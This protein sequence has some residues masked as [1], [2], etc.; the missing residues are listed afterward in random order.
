MSAM[1]ARSGLR[2]PTAVVLLVL[3]ALAGCGSQV[4]TSSSV[5][6]SVP[7]GV[8]DVRGTVLSLDV[9]RR[10][11]EIDQ[12]AMPGVMPAM[13]MPYEVVDPGLLQGLAPRDRVQG[14]LRVD[15]RGYVLTALRKI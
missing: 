15:S 7:E 2:V 5:S 10:L 4:T 14:T 1:T 6:G 11:V 3:S 9:A 8:Y 12:E 13:V